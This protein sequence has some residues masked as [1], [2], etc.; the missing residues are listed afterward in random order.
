MAATLAFRVSSAIIVR[1]RRSLPVTR[2]RIRVASFTLAF[3]AII[4]VWIFLEERLSTEGPFD[5][6]IEDASFLH[7]AV[8]QDSH[9]STVEKVQ[10]TVVDT[11][12]P[13]TATFDVA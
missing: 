7:H 8:R 4:Q 1:R 5:I 13:G 9:S 10:E 3:L 11:S 2:S 12:A 6:G